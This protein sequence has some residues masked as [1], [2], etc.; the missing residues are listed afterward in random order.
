MKTAASIIAVFGV[1]NFL[2]LPMGLFRSHTAPWARL[3]TESILGAL[4]IF[5]AIGIWKRHIAAW[6]LG[7]LAIAGVPSILL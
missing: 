1:L 6:R 2:A 4:M 3:L 7:F 5:I